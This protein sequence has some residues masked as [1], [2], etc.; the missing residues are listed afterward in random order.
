[1]YRKIIKRILNAAVMISA[2]TAL[3]FNAAAAGLAFL[4][5]SFSEE[6]QLSVYLSDVPSSISKV[7][8]LIGGNECEYISGNFVEGS[9]SKIQTVFFIDASQSIT[10]DMRDKITTFLNRMIDSKISTDDEYSIC[11]FTGS[12]NYICEF[13]SDRYELEKAVENIKFT[14]EASYIYDG[15]KKIT[16][17]LA[18]N[19][20]NCYKKVILITDGK[21]NSATGSIYDIIRDSLKENMIT[22]DCICIETG[23]NLEKI[24]IIESFSSLTNGKVFRLNEKTTIENVADTILGG[25]ENVYQANFSVP[26]SV[27]DG[28]VKNLK[29]SITTPAETSSVSYDVRMPMVKH[30]AEAVTEAASETTTAATTE[31]QAPVVVVEQPDNNN[32][33][34]IVVIIIA[35]LIFV[36]CIAA[37]ICI[38]L[39]KKNNNNSAAAVPVSAPGKLDESD[40]TEFIGG[41]SSGGG[42][43]S[44]LFS[45]DPVFRITLTDENDPGKEFS[46]STSGNIV[47]GRSA[48]E[49]TIVVDYDKSI[50]KSHCKIFAE[51]GK[52]YVQDLNSANKTFVNGCQVTDKDELTDGCVLKLGRVSFKVKITGR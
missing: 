21:E 24:K 7:E 27:L 51:S 26:Y 5:S 31:A 10:F 32:N 36:I 6:N 37:I 19:G 33:M 2:L 3:S 16:D 17:D 48:G 49:A 1:M 23:D 50:S 47:M 30:E 52:V 9:G 29:V 35:V 22:I 14:G 40:E 15:I 20:E 13:E 43:T 41:S 39:S 42:E 8:C 18:N 44:F 45:T 28:S 12:I 46:A 34:L 38:M 25:Y 11:T 4:E